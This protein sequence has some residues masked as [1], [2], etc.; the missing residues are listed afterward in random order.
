MAPS[1]AVAPFSSLWKLKAPPRVLAFVW[2]ALGGR[3]LTIDNLRRG[4]RILVDAC[5][6]CL[7]GE[8]TVDHLLLHCKIAL[9]LWNFVLT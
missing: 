6:M 8:E 7:V 3:S 2:I 4:N 9:M 1:E 5:S